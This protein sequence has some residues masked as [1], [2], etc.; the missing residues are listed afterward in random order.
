MCRSIRN[1]RH[2]DDP[3]TTG[4]VEAAARQFVR[5]VTGF[6]KPS[7]RNAEAFEAAIA[8]I[9]LVS[10]RLIVAVGGDVEEGPDR[11]PPARAYSDADRERWRI[12]DER[13]RDEMRRDHAHP[14]P[15]GA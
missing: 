9:A 4:E 15:A 14:H 5:K 7:Q 12:R 1:L 8:E 10:Q 2:E 11:K 3:A 13:R 6:Q